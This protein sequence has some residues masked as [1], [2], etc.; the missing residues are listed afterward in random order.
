MKLNIQQAIDVFNVKNAGKKRLNKSLLAQLVIVDRKKRGGGE[1][2]VVYKRQLMSAWD[3]GQYFA[4][5][6]DK[7]IKAIADVCGVTVEFLTKK[8]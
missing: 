1:A 3:K 8:D 5:P 2:T 6:T 7:E 4:K